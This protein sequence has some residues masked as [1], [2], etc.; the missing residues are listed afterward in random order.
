MTRR[1]LVV[2][3]GSVA[4]ATIALTAAWKHAPLLV[5]NAS[6]SVPIGLYA[7]R[8]AGRLASDELVVMQPP[9]TLADFLANGHYLPR[10]VPL[11]KHVAALPGAIVCRNGLTVSID[12]F[13]RAEAR[14]RDHAGR[15]L[16]SWSGCRTIADDEVFLLNASEPASLD[17]RYFGPLSSSRMVGRAV[18]IW[19]EQRR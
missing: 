3:T 17:S 18:P 4:I 2:A 1:T 19:T 16:P 14:E 10:G 12:G 15:L 13:V 5:W 9:E 6:A 11:I 7:V 8:D